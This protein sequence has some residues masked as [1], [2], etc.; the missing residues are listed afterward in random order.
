M[1]YLPED[2]LH[3]LAGARNRIADNNI[4]NFFSNFKVYKVNHIKK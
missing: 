4:V 2:W 3:T 1:E